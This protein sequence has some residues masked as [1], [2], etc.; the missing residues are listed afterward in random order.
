MVAS[1]GTYF[2]VPPPSGADA[3]AHEKCATK[4]DVEREI[5]NCMFKRGGKV[6]GYLSYFPLC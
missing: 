2:L 1:T 3:F 5:G 6:D 4:D